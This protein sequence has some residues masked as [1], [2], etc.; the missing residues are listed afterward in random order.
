MSDLSGNGHHIQCPLCEGKGHMLRSELAAKLA[1]H[2]FEARLTACRQ[3]LM[4]PDENRLSDSAEAANDFNREV[5]KG[6]VTRI[7][8][9]RSPKE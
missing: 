6:P 9:R 7:L 4:K 1:D 5:L 8:W 2:D 3:Q